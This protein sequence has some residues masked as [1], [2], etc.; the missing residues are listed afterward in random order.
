MNKEV[1]RY[2]YQT[3]IDSKDQLERKVTV[4]YKYDPENSQVLYGA[5]IFRKER[6]DEFF[7]KGSHRKTAQSRLVKCPVRISVAPGHLSQIESEIREA[8]RTRGVSGK[9]L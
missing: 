6:A 7:N 4:A 1:V 3:E 5:T 9:R 2:F 8:I